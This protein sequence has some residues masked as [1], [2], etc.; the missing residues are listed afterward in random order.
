MIEINNLIRYRWMDYKENP[1]ELLYKK[2][3]NQ[4]TIKE[5]SKIVGLAI[6]FLTTRPITPNIGSLLVSLN[7]GLIQVWSHHP[8]GGLLG[9]FTAIHT[10]KDYCL[11][12]S[13][14]PENNF[15]ITGELQILEIYDNLLL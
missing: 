10:D 15:L 11:S 6:L 7:S 5:N 3:E 1:C 8:A 2:S 14:D 13:S 12:L 4:N 9:D